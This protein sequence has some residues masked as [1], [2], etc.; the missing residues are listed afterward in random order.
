MTQ[1]LW[2]KSKLMGVGVSK[3]KSGSIFIVANY[4][5]RGNVYGFFEENLP[6]FTKKDIEAAK[7]AQEKADRELKTP[8]I[9]VMRFD[10]GSMSPLSEQDSSFGSFPLKNSP[11]GSLPLKNSQLEDSPFGNLLLSNNPFGNSPFGRN[12]MLG[13]LGRF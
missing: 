13:N 1:L 3:N 8:K 10:S 2:K 6:K 4:N 9:K 11:F 12:S 5:P 7:K